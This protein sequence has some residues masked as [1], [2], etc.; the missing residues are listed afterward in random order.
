VHFLVIPKNR[1]GLSRLSK[2]TEA[3][4]PL[5]GHLM[6]VAQHVAKEQGLGTDGY[7][8]VGES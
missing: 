3:H 6:F 4:K 8:L 1:E 7:R 2:A 5:L